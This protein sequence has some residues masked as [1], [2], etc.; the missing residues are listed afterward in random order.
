[1]NSTQSAFTQKSMKARVQQN[2]EGK[3][4]IDQVHIPG[5]DIVKGYWQVE[6]KDDET[7]FG[8]YDIQS[9]ICEQKETE[10]S[11]KSLRSF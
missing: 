10:K 9:T 2:P 5:G 8:H 11:L 1:M 7:D 3:Y 4:H 6:D